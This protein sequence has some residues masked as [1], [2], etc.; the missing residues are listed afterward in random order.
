L[1]TA[2]ADVIIS[3]IGMPGMDG[4]EMMRRFRSQ[5]DEHAARTPAVALTAHATSADRERSMAA[6][7]QHHLAKPVDV[8]ELLRVIA[9]LAN[10]AE[11]TRKN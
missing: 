11:S 4:W 7:F 5:S 10:G 3:D 8:D 9:R 6:G 1:S 2:S